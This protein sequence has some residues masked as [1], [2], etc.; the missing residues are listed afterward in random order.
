MAKKILYFTLQLEMLRKGETQTD[1]A[2]LIG[3]TQ[4]TVSNKLTGKT[5]WNIGEIDTLCKHY[6]K[7]YYELFDKE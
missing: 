6:N 2:K 4:E 1:L 5:Q 7:N 3:I